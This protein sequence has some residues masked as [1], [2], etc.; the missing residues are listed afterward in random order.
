[1]NRRRWMWTPL[2]LVLVVPLLGQSGKNSAKQMDSQV[3]DFFIV[4]SVDLGKKQILLKRPTEVTELVR[5]N[6]D[7]RY[8][9]EHGKAIQ[10]SDLR[11]GDTVYISLKHSDEPPLALIIR[12]GPMTVEVLR[13]RYLGTKN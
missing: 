4:S 5:V 7:T 12:K 11:A 2:V 9:D 8:L 6:G 1:M 3:G 13:D 10:L